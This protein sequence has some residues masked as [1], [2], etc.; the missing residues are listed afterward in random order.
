[1]DDAIADLTRRLVAFRDE[2][3]WAQ[4]HTLKNLMVSLDIEASE[5]LELAQWQTDSEVESR[6]KDDKA[7][8]DSLQNEVADVFLYLLLI[9]ER[10]GVD[11]V[12]AA[13][14]KIDANATR[15]PAHK[16]RGNA[17]KHTEL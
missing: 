17:R 2:R 4:F 12:A 9:C 5:L 13:R 14:A 3:D 6:L 11:P 15:Y 7:F 10:A 16:A 1:M 8:H